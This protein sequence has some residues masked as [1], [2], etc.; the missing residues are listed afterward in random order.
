MSDWSEVERN[1]STTLAPILE[2]ALSGAN[3]TRG[4]LVRLL[5]PA[6]DGERA[7]IRIAA[8]EARRRH[9]GDRIFTYGFVYLSTWCRNDCLFCGYRSTN[10]EA[11]RYRKNSGEI[12]AASKLLAGQGVNLIDLTMGEDPASDEPGYIDEIAGLI[13]EVRRVTGLPVMISPGVASRTA[14]EKYKAAGAEWYACYQETHNR[15]LFD[16]LR[17]G[18]NY[19][20]RW[21]SKLDAAGI[22]LRVEEGTLCGVGETAEDLADSILAMRHPAFGQVRAM[23]FVPP[24]EAAGAPLGRWAPSPPPGQAQ[25]REVDVIAA[26]RLAHPDRLIPASL[27]VEG[28]AGLKTRLDAGA[29]VITSLVPAD[30]DLAGVAQ[31]CLDIDNQARSVAGVRPVVESEGLR[32]AGPAEYRVWLETAPR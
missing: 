6:D 9:T 2:K 10:P 16:R 7:A 11:R 4:D 1:V 28:L 32:L 3:L 27:D 15:Q 8:R 5:S 18:Q 12:L 21:Q 31:A 20:I 22:G 30:M 26:L 13:A 29:N 19:E 24:A 17:T 23:G 25:A 14:L